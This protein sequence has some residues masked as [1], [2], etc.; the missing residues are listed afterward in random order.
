[1]FEHWDLRAQ[2]QGA[3]QNDARPPASIEHLLPK[4]NENSFND[5]LIRKNIREQDMSKFEEIRQ[6][7]YLYETTGSNMTHCSLMGA[8]DVF[9]TTGK[10]H[11]PDS[12]QVQ[13]QLFE[14]IAWL[15]PKKMYL[16]ISERQ[17]QRFPFIEDLDI[18]ASTDWR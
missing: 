8:Q 11:F 16:Y 2:L 12:L 17:T 6:F 1:M 10:W 4:R 18:Q 5:R 14:N 9:T 15:F 13:K 3:L 7:F